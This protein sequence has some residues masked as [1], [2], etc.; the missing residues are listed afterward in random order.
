M[1]NPQQ[2]AAADVMVTA[3]NS[4]HD[5]GY[6][7]GQPGVHSGSTMDW[8]KGAAGIKYSY[9]LELRDDGMTDLLH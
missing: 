7:H 3:M 9:L 1:C 5:Q 4:V 8:A 2:I 6:I